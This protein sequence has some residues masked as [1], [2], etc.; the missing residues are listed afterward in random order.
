LLAD[1]QSLMMVPLLASHSEPSERWHMFREHLGV[2]EL[3]SAYC[4]DVIRDLLPLST[5]SVTA[6]SPAC[7]GEEHGGKVLR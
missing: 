4:P 6:V 5:H 2:C 7:S 1:S 3:S